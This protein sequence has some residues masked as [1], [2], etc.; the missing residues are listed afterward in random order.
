MPIYRNVIFY[1]TENQ[2]GT[3]IFPCRALNGY[4]DERHYGIDDRADAG[5]ITAL[6]QEL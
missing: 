3:G 5:T 1:I 6:Q 2:A 4:Q